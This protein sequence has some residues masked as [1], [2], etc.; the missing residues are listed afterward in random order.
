MRE[1]G[2]VEG[3]NLIIEVRWPQR[4]FEQEPGVAAEFVR[5]NVDVVVAWGTQAVAAA[6]TATATIPII[7]VSVSDPVG[8]GFVASMARPGGNVTGVTP[9]NPDIS[10]KLVE[11][12]REIVPGMKQVG[13]VFNSK[14]PG[15]TAQMRGTEDAALDLASNLGSSRPAP[16]RNLSAHSHI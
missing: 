8:A 10:G 11:L 2:Y 6:R 5:A 14:N 13:V 16:S 9:I 1:R 3:Q 4:S 15:A 7:M 12:L